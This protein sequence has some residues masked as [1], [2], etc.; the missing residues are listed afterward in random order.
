MKCWMSFSSE[1]CPRLPPKYAKILKY[2]K[3]NLCCVMWSP[4]IGIAKYCNDLDI[5]IFHI[6]FL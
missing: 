6:L 1:S 4:K 2:A 3:E 5:N